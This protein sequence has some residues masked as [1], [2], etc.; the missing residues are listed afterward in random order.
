LSPLLLLLLHRR[1]ITRSIREHPQL[2]LPDRLIVPV[3]SLTFGVMG[4]GAASMPPGGGA[5]AE[6]IRRDMGVDVLV[7]GGGHAVRLVAGGSPGGGGGG[8]GGGGVGGMGGMGMGLGLSWGEES[9]KVGGRRSG[10]G[11]GRGLLVDPG[12][13]RWWTEGGWEVPACWVVWWGAGEASGEE[14]GVEQAHAQRPR[15]HAVCLGGLVCVVWGV[16]TAAVA[17]SDGRRD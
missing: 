16:R 6:A 11:G 9:S 2:D 15:S 17:A 10:G 4:T 5:A 3:G 14:R 7:G 12:T 1:F 13:V 8:G